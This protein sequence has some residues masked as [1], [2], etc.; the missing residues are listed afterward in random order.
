MSI[1]FTFNNTHSRDMGVV[2]K[3]TDRTLLPAKRV[4]RYVIPGKSGTY[5][6]EDGYDN[7]E[8]VCEVS[9]VG[10]SYRYPGVRS[11][12]RAVAGWLSGEGLLVFDDEPEK[13]YQAKV[14]GGVSIEQI[15]VTGHCEVVFS[16]APFAESLEYN[17]QRATS[18]SLP[19]TET[20]NVNGTQETDCLVYITARGK[21]KD[22]TVTRIKVN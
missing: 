1:G 5:D 6:I 13:A 15:A 9:F 3:S 10:E 20:V 8:I 19:H 11:R 17:Q 18:V 16:C 12:A 21:I 22:L 2:F 14:I 7:R 4:T